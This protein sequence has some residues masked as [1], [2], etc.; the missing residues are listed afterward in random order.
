MQTRSQLKNSRNIIM[1]KKEDYMK[2]KLLRNVEV[3][4]KVCY[5]PSKVCNIFLENFFIN[6][7]NLIYGISIA[8]E[9][10]ELHTFERS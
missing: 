9:V 2:N 1:N 8:A 5:G 6:I 10:N 3:T 4:N 7:Q